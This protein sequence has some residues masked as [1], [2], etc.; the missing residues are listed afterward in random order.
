MS[1]CLGLYINDNIVKYAKMTMDNNSKNITLE[2]YGIRYVKDSVKNVIS[3]IVEE[4]NSTKDLIAINSQKDIFLNYSMFDQ[5]GSKNFSSDVAKMEFESWCEKNAKVQAK[6]SYVFKISDVINKE[7]KFNC[8]LNIT[9]KDTINEYSDVGISKVTNM[10]PSQFLMNRLVPQDEENYILVNLDDRLSISVVVGKQVSDFRF[11]E[12][13]MRDL[14]SKFSQK[15]GS[16]QKA[17]EACKQL[18]VYSDEETNNDVELEEIAEPVLQEILKSVAVIVNKY[19]DNVDKIILT[20]QGIVFTNIDIL[21]REYL[22]V[23][24]EILKPE[25]LRDTSNVR[26]LAEALETTQAMAIA[27]EA[28]SP[29]EPKLNYIKLSGK[30]KKQFNKFV[31][32]ET[33]ENNGQKTEKIKEEKVKKSLPTFQEAAFMPYITCFGIVCA[34][35]IIAYVTFSVLYSSSVRKTLNSIEIAK[36]HIVEEKNKVT[37]DISHINTNYAKYKG[38]NE[39]VEETVKEIENS[40]VKKYST[41]NVASFLQNMIKVTPKNIQILSI[42]SDDNKNIVMKA[43]ADSYPALGYFISELKLNGPLNN[44]KIISVENSTST[45]VEIGGEL[46]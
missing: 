20:G 39:R 28:I 14:I 36:N 6:Y 9:E 41:Y 10:Y 43:R 27:L 17:Y 45:I 37:S 34:L 24:C 7:N 26:N 23:K 22:N 11:Y 32:K 18:N 21:F 2:N 4:T 33:K 1:G 46:P 5:H 19:R 42:K 8:A 30:F 12:F 25:F 31:S 16:Y 15:V 29:R 13:G 40:K 38:I 3:A 44:V 35:A